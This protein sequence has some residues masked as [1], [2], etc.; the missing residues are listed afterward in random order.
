MLYLASPGS[1]TNRPVGLH[2]A[3][4]S[5]ASVSCAKVVVGWGN[6]K[7]TGKDSSSSQTGPL[8]GVDSPGPA[9]SEL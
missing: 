1:G 3:Y 7:R 2:E 6:Q 4:P 8:L 9:S 5:W